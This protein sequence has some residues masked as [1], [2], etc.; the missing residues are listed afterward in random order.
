ME[1]KK[2][3]LFDFIRDQIVMNGIAPTQQEMMKGLGTKSKR[4]LDL[5]IQELVDDGWIHR[6]AGK[7]RGITLT[8]ITLPRQFPIAKISAGTPLEPIPDKHRF[9]IYAMLFPP[10]A[11]PYV[12]NGQSM[13]NEGFQDGDL[14]IF[15]P[16]RNNEIKN[17]DLV[18]AQIDGTDAAFRRIYIRP[19]QIILEA[20]NPENKTL[21]YEPERVEVRGKF[22]KLIGMNR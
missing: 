6:R 16:A 13:I 14:V 12:I 17:G 22:H 11:F 5:M 4:H 15:L 9:D 10:G 3:E 18:Y 2:L 1:P 20:G 21:F 8:D 19:D 7:R